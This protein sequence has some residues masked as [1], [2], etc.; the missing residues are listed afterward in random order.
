MGDAAPPPPFR[1]AASDRAEAGTAGTALDFNLR[2]MRR[3][4][5]EIHGNARQGAA[6]RVPRLKRVSRPNTRMVEVEEQLRQAVRAAKEADPGLRFVD[7]RLVLQQLLEEGDQGGGA[8][9]RKQRQKV[10]DKVR[11]RRSR[12]IDIGQF[13]AVIN[14]ADTK[15]EERR[16]R[17]PYRLPLRGLNM[18]L[19]DD[20]VMG[21]FQRFTGESTLLKYDTLVQRLYAGDAHNAAQQGTRLGPYCRGEPNPSDPDRPG[22]NWSGVILKAPHFAKSSA[23]PPSNWD[24]CGTQIC[25]RSSN[26]PSAVLKLEHVYGYSGLSN[27]SPNLFYVRGSADG[28]FNV[29]YYS[30]AVGVVYEE[31]RVQD[32]DATSVMALTKLPDAEL[33]ELIVDLDVD[34]GA[35]AQLRR[36]VVDA[37]A[38]PESSPAG[39][40]ELLGDALQDKVPM[41]EDRLQAVHEE[42]K[43]SSS[44]QPR[45]RFFVRHNDDITCTAVHPELE[46]VATGQSMASKQRGSDGSTGGKG[47]CV[48]IWNAR[49]VGV[50]GSSSEPKKL[51]LP[52]GDTTLCAMAF[53]ADGWLLTTISAEHDTATHHV[54]V[55]DWERG[56]L[57]CSAVACRG[58]PPHVFGCVWNRFESWEPDEN[59]NLPEGISSFVT[60]GRKSIMMWEYMMGEEGRPPSIQAPK[61][62]PKVGR[63]GGPPSDVLTACYVRRDVVLAGTSLGTI[64]AWVGSSPAAKSWAPYRPAKRAT[65]EEDDGQWG[66]REGGCTLIRMH[67]TKDDR[68][69]TA[70]G[71]KY[72][73]GVTII[74][75]KIISADAPKLPA[76]HAAMKLGK[77]EK[78]HCPIILEKQRA[79]R[80]APDGPLS[81][82][83]PMVIGL[84]WHPTDLDVFI[85]GDTGND[86]YEGRFIPFDSPEL[87]PVLVGDEAL[88]TARADPEDPKGALIELVV[89]A[90]TNPASETYDPHVD[91]EDLQQDLTLLGGKDL[92]ARAEAIVAEMVPSLERRQLMEGASSCVFGTAVHPSKQH[93]YSTA[94]ED[95]HLYL[96]D[97]KKRACIRQVRVARLG[98]LPGKRPVDWPM[99]K[100][101]P[102][103]KGDVLRVR[104]CAFSPDGK[105]LA[106]STGSDS[107]RSG[108]YT[109]AT[110]RRTWSHYDKGGVVRIYLLNTQPDT[111]AEDVLLSPDFGGVKDE[112]M[113]DLVLCEHKISSEGI[114]CLSFSPDSRHLACGS[115][116]NFVYLIDTEQKLVRPPRSQPKGTAA[117]MEAMDR[118]GSWDP[119]NNRLIVARSAAVHSSHITHMDWSVPDGGIDENGEQCSLLQTSSGAHELLYLDV[120]SG[121]ELRSKLQGEN[122]GS[123][124]KRAEAAGIDE[125]RVDKLVR[126]GDTA[127]AIDAIA[128]ARTGRLVNASQ[129]NTPWLAWTATLGF[130][131]MGMWRSGPFALVC[132]SVCSI[133][134]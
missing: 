77:S 124:K 103:G 26:I 85:L 107:G 123:L 40:S 7:A 98:H 122:M 116:D 35:E 94:C 3:P 2:L 55:W 13:R 15:P 101:W 46:M 97:A 42:A 67:C 50:K 28:A 81:G 86:I 133:Q 30:A 127:A 104:A 32:E 131:V 18:A 8:E 37:A 114:D 4:G 118:A 29:A 72:G 56:S 16:P 125:R 83:A 64:A 73:S 24:E 95:G 9:A 58:E 34:S 11:P 66:F 52:D 84:D 65:S 76:S 70:G 113:D 31:T 23:M 134:L 99:G 93:I 121:R 132:P 106:V 63:W 112:E 59:G 78:V 92:Y 130:D 75:W 71:E 27:T 111:S 88:E 90:T 19:P 69:L 62:S 82:P 128:A 1:S 61:R 91:P 126:N 22:W 60:Y 53:S 105:K 21:L 47:G 79:V 115:H 14:N 57:H 44:A 108:V 89:G 87:N 5:V 25:R 6:A 109:S 68:V 49:T 38:D 117:R 100:D 36:K 10:G 39:V 43:L 33:D 17:N 96:W 119:R 41:V 74:E 51:Q 12:L 48:Y 45:Q 129:R 110:G 102:T 54:R 20:D 120:T 80:I